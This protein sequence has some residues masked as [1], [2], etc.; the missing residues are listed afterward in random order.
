MKLST[1]FIIDTV[2]GV[3][4]GLAFIIAPAMGIGVF[5]IEATPGAVNLARSIGGMSLGLAVITWVA[6][7]ASASKARDAIV[8]GLVV[9]FAL[10]GV[11]DVVSTW[12]GALNS[13]GWAGAALFF[14]LAILN[15]VA[16]RAAMSEN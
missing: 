5:G 16:G 13:V 9:A 12:Q 11:N 15:A 2:G 1:V 14:V 3:L 4:F 8:L 10:L 6:R 7:N